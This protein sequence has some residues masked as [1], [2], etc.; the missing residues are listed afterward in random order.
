MRLLLRLLLP[1]T[2][3]AKALPADARRRSPSTDSGRVPGRSKGRVHHAQTTPTWSRGF[4]QQRA[5]SLLN[6]RKQK[7]RR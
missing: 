1:A 6:L 7:E 2:A 4:L 5:R 3:V